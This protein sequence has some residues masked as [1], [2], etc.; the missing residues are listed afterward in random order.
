MIDAEGVVPLLDD[1]IPINE[2]EGEVEETDDDEEAC[3]DACCDDEDPFSEPGVVTT[4]EEDCL[5]NSSESTSL[6]QHASGN[7]HKSHLRD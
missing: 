1:T 5:V 2:T 4:A 6:Q 7:G 3:G